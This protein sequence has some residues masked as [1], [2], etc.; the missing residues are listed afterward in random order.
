MLSVFPIM[1]L[2]LLAHTLLRLFFGG[3]LLYLG[4]THAFR[5]RQGLIAVL[6]E[7]WKRSAAFLVSYLALVECV[8]G[9]LIIVG[10]WTQVAAL[11]A[12]ILGLKMIIFAKRFAHPAI[13]SRI[14]WVMVIGAGLSLTITGAGA[15]AIDLPF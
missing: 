3:A 15:F 9:V 2:S 10:A 4:V 14:F 5:E 1:F 11:L 6:R 13:P 7:H 8:L 12:A